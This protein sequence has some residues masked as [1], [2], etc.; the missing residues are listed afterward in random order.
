MI[1]D[2]IHDGDYVVIQEKET[3]SNGDVVVALV[4]DSEATL[5]RYY[6]EVGRIRLQP[7]NATMEPIYIT[8]DMDLKIQG[9][10]IGLIR[11]Y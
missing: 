3:A 11:R 10:V 6:K 7:A 9:T 5:K 8:P 4:N 1:D 2:G